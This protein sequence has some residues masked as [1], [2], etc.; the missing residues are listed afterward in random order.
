MQF[1]LY[2]NELNINLREVDILEKF[3]MKYRMKRT[4]FWKVIVSLYR[5]SK[6]DEICDSW[7]H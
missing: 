6:K 1:L 4:I 2:T 7:G 5:K 3:S